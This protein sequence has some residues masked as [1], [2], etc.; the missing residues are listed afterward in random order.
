MLKFFDPSK[1][2]EIFCDASSSL[3]A[4]LLKDDHTVAVSSRSL[5]DTETCYAQIEKEILSIV[6]TCTKFHN[7]IFGN[8]VIAYNDHKP[9]EDIL[10]NPPPYPMQIQSMHLQLQWYDLTVRY[11]QG[12]DMELP[13]TLSRAQLPR[14]SRKLKV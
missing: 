9:L 14:K 5:P 8:H 4:V 1:P 13:D 10:R 6:H 3:G 7:F 12:K 11:R 2:V